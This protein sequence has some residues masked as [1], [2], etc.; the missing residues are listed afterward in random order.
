MLLF[1]PYS[2]RIHRGNRDA[3]QHPQALHWSHPHSNRC[4]CSGACYIGLDGAEEQ[5]GTHNRDLRRQLY[6]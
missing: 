1:S 3:V 6:R 4:E 2:G 5:D